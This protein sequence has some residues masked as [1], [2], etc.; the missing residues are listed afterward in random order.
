MSRLAFTD[1]SVNCGIVDYSNI[2][3]DKIH[4]PSTRKCYTNRQFLNDLTCWVASTH[5]EIFCSVVHIY[6]QVG[7][8]LCH[9]YSY[10][11]PQLCNNL[12]VTK[13]L[14][15]TITAAG[16]WKVG[17]ILKNS[18][19]LGIAEND[20]K[21]LWIGASQN[22]QMCA[23]IS[24]SSWKIKIVLSVACIIYKSSL[25]TKRKTPEDILCHDAVKVS[26]SISPEAWPAPGAGS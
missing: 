1:S 17:R 15:W 8:V 10:Y 22:T 13:Y 18:G 4:L 16:I 2:L 14:H 9:F 23:M 7:P 26:T 5:S 20:C 12:V 11:C 6:V 24:G 19:I 3:T 25:L 21:L